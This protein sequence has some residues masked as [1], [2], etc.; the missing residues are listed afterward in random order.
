AASAFHYF[1][2]ARLVCG[3]LDTFTLATF[4]SHVGEL[5]RARLAPPAAGELGLMRRIF[6]ATSGH[7]PHSSGRCTRD[8][9]SRVVAYS[10]RP[11]RTIESRASCGRDART[12]G[13]HSALSDADGEKRTTERRRMLAAASAARRLLYNC[14]VRILVAFFAA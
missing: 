11:R 12:S 10:R 2:G 7:A 1:V 8:S 4:E 3:M 5:F 9:N 14:Y 6:F 13:P